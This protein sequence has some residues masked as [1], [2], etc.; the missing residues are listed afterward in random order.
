MKRFILLCASVLAIGACATQQPPPAAPAPATSITPTNYAAGSPANTTTAFDG[1]W[2]VWSHTEHE[3]GRR[4]PSGRGLPELPKLQQCAK[5]D[6]RQ[7]SRSAR[8]QHPQVPRIRNATRCTGHA[9]Q[10]WSEIRG[11]DKFPKCACG[12]GSRGLCVRRVVE[13]G[14]TCPRAPWCGSAGATIEMMGPM[15]GSVMT[16]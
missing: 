4:Y 2:V 12:Q 6:H 13:A 5:F 16:R 14:L 15:P 9:D 10:C 8:F 7:W 11:A 3:R 1:T